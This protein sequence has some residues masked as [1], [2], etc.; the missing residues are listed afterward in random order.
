[1]AQNPLKE[2]LKEYE[3]KRIIAEQKAEEKKNKIFFQYPELQKVENEIHS[4]AIQS[5]KFA[6]T[7][8]HTIN[9]SD[10]SKNLEKLKKQKQAI[11]KSLNISEKDLAPIYECNICQ[12]T[13]YVKKEN[14]IVMC[15]CLKQRLYNSLYNT[16]NMGDLEKENFSTFDLNYYSSECSPEKYHSNL[17]PRENIKKIKTICQDFI[18]NFSSNQQKNLLFT[19]NTGLGKTFLSNCIAKE[20]LEKG[21]TVLYQTSQ[22][23]L[24]HII[25]NRFHSQS[26]DN[27]EQ[28]V[29]DVDLLIIDDLGTESINSIKL[30]ELFN[31]LNTRILNQNRKLSKTIISTNLTLQDLFAIYDERIVSRLVG[32]YTICRF[33]GEDIRFLKKGV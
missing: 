23:L 27:F 2:I 19:G 29:L 13:G 20:I 10:F 22:N 5:A 6:L 18:T 25:N 30:A 26:S 32:Y 14:H 24:D 7:S 8:G 11:L 3:E 15:N 28:T 12:D 1:M 33:F 21:H 9:I 16:S 4:Y 31:I 17:S